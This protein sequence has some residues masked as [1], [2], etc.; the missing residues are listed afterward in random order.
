M[1]DSNLSGY[2]VR[3][4]PGAPPAIRRTRL[5]AL[6]W[7]ATAIS[8]AVVWLQLLVLTL[9]RDVTTLPLIYA[10]P[11]V[12]VVLLLAFGGFRIQV[13]PATAL[14]GVVLTSLLVALLGPSHLL[15][16]SLSLTTYSSA[17]LL[18]LVRGPDDSGRSAVGSWRN[19]LVV[20]AVFH[21]LVGITQLVGAGFP[22]RLPYRDFSPDVFSSVFGDGGHRLVPLIVAPAAVLVALRSMRSGVRVADVALLA[23]LL[24]GIIAP[25]SNAAIM[26]LLVA[27]GLMYVTVAA[28]SFVRAVQA[29]RPRV[30][31]PSM[32]LTALA[33]PILV[34]CGGLAVAASLAV[35]GLPHFRDSITRIVESPGD[36]VRSP[37]TAVALQTILQLPRDVPTQPVFGLG[38]GN[39]S[40]W[41]QL[42]LSGVYAE[43][44]LDGTGVGLVPVSYRAEAWNYVLFHMTAEMRA[45]YGFYYIDSIATQPWS[46]WQSLYAETGLLGL[47]LIA[48]ALVAPLR[49][50]RLVRGDSGVLRDTKL[51]VGFSLWFVVVMGF[52]DNLFE[53]PW[54]MVP[55]LLALALLPSRQRR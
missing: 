34:V 12:T 31:L 19:A 50:L 16:V 26:G 37:K 53:Y 40:S 48:M 45:R 51:M 5:G 55:P 39:Y 33:V 42:L 3:A 2:V 27:G 25:G 20:V 52:T 35:G 54:L 23:L 46:S 6:R 18:V 17:F 14:A 24:V 9:P 49:R 8:R 28:G 21:S 38:L 11:L 10:S 4:D 30:R 32:R 29:A 13:G 1:H 15:N 47:A 44:F 7:K 43:R 41:S 36:S 22:A